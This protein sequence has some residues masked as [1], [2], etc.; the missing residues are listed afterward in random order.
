MKPGVTQGALQTF[1]FLI[2]AEPFKYDCWPPPGINHKL[3]AVCADI[4]YSL[5]PPS[6]YNSDS[7]CET[8]WL[9]CLWACSLTISCRTLKVHEIW[10]RKRQSSALKNKRKMSRLNYPGHSGSFTCKPTQQIIPCCCCPLGI[11]NVFH[12]GREELISNGWDSNLFCGR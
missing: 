2:S 12:T 1:P 10:W 6:S 5:L 9:C 11:G 4:N 8:A 7:L 3:E